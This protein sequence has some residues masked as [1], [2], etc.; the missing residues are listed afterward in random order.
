VILFLF[1]LVNAGVVFTALAEPTWL[2]LGGLVI[3]KPIGVVL[4]GLI[5]A[6]LLRFGL[7]EGMRVAELFIVGL[8]AGIGFTVAL[9]FAAVAFDP[10]PVQDAAKIG[11][12]F[13]LVAALAA[14][15]AGKLL[16]VEKR[17]A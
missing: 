1:G 3:G 8:V 15:V 16:K 10:G 5:A 12:L 6:R 14:L 7:P 9:F 17:G 4:F 2:V 13:S 11:A